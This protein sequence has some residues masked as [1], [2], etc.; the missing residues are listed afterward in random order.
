MDRQT[1][2]RIGHQLIRLE[3]YLNKITANNQALDEFQQRVTRENTAYQEMVDSIIA[4][5]KAQG[6]EVDPT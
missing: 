4:K 6:I 3:D 5:L 2:V 1:M